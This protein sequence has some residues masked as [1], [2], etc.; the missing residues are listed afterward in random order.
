M[1]TITALPPAPTR[2]DPANFSAKGDALMTALPTFVTETNTVAG[3]V[4]AAAAAA[5]ASVT[6]AA[7]HVTS[8]STQANN[9]ANSATAAAN[10]ATNAANSATTAAGYVTAAAAQ[11]T[12]AANSAAAAA[13][14][15]DSFDD[16]YL[17]A[18]AANPTT[19]NDGNALLVGAIYWNTTSSE[20]RVWNGAAF[21]TA[22]NP[23]P[24]DVPSVTG[25]STE[26]LTNDGVVPT[27]V[28]RITAVHMPAYFYGQL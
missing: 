24:G 25:H 20:W 11:A 23:T 14:S 28:S 8:A 3:E 2:A 13:A 17:G 9:A 7:G 26:I 4:N 10:S 19:D 21:V 22:Y 16:R 27:W 1:T 18:K 12:D 5:A 6:T 15:F